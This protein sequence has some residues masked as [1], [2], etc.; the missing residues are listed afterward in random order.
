VILRPVTDADAAELLRWRHPDRYETYD[1]GGDE[2]L[3]SHYAAEEDDVLVGYCCFGAEARVDGVHDEPGVLDVGWGLRPDLMGQ[4]RGRA[5]I[6]TILALAREL[7]HPERFRIA[8][9]DWNERSQRAAASA[10]F[11][12]TGSVQ[13]QQGRF[14][15]FERPA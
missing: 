2:E 6:E 8:V 11:E 3:S 9:L 10:G 4:G 13:E 15:L 12:P 5:F 14:L 1:F 7:Y